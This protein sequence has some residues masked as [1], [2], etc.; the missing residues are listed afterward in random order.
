MRTKPT[1]SATVLVSL[2]F[3][4]CGGGGSAESGLDASSR[5]ADG[6]R[7]GSGEDSASEAGGD[8]RSSGSVDGGSH[9]EGGSP[10]FE[11]G[12]AAGAPMAPSNVKAYAT[13]EGVYV[14]FAPPSDSGAS[15]ITR[16][17]ATTSTGHSASVTATR[18]Q[19][20]HN[21][22]SYEQLN[23]RIDID[24]LAAGTNVTVTVRASNASGTS[25]ASPASNAVTPLAG[26]PTYVAGGGNTAESPAWGDYSYSGEVYYG[27]TPHTASRNGTG[28]YSAPTNPTNAAWNVVEFDNDDANGGF[29]P[30]FHHQDPD[31]TQ[32]GRLN[33]V[34]YKDLVISVYP[35]ADQTSFQQGLYLGFLRCLWVNGVVGTGG[36]SSLVDPT[37]NWPADI[38]ATA[39]VTDITTGSLVNVASNTSTTLTFTSPMT[40][41]AGDFYE[42]SVPDVGI[43]QQIVVGNGTATAYGPTSLVSGQWNTFTIPFTAF[44]GGS[45]SFTQVSGGQIL[46]F[47]AVLS[48]NSD[49][50]HYFA[51]VG[52]Q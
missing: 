6:G 21:T 32:N 15:A 47:N 35:T 50:V 2:V 51:N 4:A 1:F 22:L 28:S 36:S 37:Q 24:G 14:L 3:V 44:D 25:A 30:F 8:A 43:G 41:N 13:T 42:I 20:E 33:L 16:Y 46:K 17:T 29:Q 10:G 26:G 12:T 38:F 48:A 45:T 40:V 5:S 31:N 18:V 19:N 27:V 11:S 49:E 34:P 39:L 23:C 9:A 7:A 52:F